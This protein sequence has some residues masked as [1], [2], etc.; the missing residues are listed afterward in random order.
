RP[1]HVWYDAFLW[2][3]P[4]YFVGG[5]VAVAAVWLLGR[6][7]AWF[8]PMVA[9]PVYLT[10]R[11]YKVYL[12]RIAD[13][14][15]HVEVV[16]ALHAQAVRGLALARRSEQ[17][18][19][20]E[21]E[22]LAVTLSTI[23]EAVVASDTRGRIVLLNHTAEVFTGWSQEQAIG[24]PV[25]DVLRVVDRES[26]R[27][28]ASPVDKVL[29][30]HAAIAHD[31][32]GALVARDGTA[33]QV[34][35]SATPIRGDDGAIVA[36]VLVAR[37]VTDAARLDEE[38]LKASKLASL[39]VLAGGIAHDFNNILTAVVGNISLAQ[40]EEGPAAQRHNLAQAEK[41]CMRAKA[42][43]HQLLTFSK[44]GA[45][46]KKVIVLRE[47]IREA[48]SFAL[49]GSNVRCEFSL[50]EG[51]WAVDADEGQI[52][53]VVNNLVINAVQAMPDGG[54][55][56]V[57]AENVPAGSDRNAAEPSQ[58]RIAIQDQGM[59]IPEEHL[60]KIFDPYFTTKQSGSGLGLATCYSIA[61]NHGG[62][63]DVSS[64]VG[65]GTTM[66]ISLPA[67]V[68]TGRPVAEEAHAAIERGKGRVL[69]MDDE[70]AIRDLARE[71]LGRLG[72]RVDVAADGREA[73][74]LYTEA[75]K[76]GDGFDTVIID[77]TV[78]GGMGGKDAIKAL[79]AL[80]PDATAIVS[81]G[82]ADDPVMS[83]YQQYGFKGVMPKPF[84]V[85]DLSRLLQRLVH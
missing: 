77:L 2:S 23:G 68:D 80:D 14:R 53:Q 55:L 29:R 57:R 22:R 74:E 79:L 54:V 34:E 15:R 3:A 44:G 69:V 43:T 59:G 45:P 41:A 4:S 31:R 49:R 39:G 1:W 85:A 9:A 13:G 63:I 28:C 32:Q 47:I 76:A 21:K 19:A 20:I 25:I 16:S 64:V 7:E 50:P 72:Y 11:T 24:S 78:P 60:S 46:L 26:G 17:A 82:Y 37:D 73:I 75:R 84:G 27:S 71:M 5:G 30:T 83:E 67:V 61:R 18:L 8:V 58:V 65:Q 40:M 51:L 33:R 12:G 35:L 81:S 38:R 36:V 48:T 70:D 56:E 6:G 62:H 42:L 52:V 10:Y 66:F